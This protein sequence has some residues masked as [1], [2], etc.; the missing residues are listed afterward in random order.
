MDYRIIYVNAEAIFAVMLIILYALERSNRKNHMPRKLDALYACFIVTII[1]DSIWIIIDGQPRLRTF[2]MILNVV[3]LS[4][5]S[6]IGYLWFLYTLDMFPSRTKLQKIKYYLAIPVVLDVLIV[7]FSPITGWAFTIDESGYYQRGAL[8]ILSFLMNYVFTML[9]SYAALAARK[10]A[11][12][13]VDKKR[14]AVAAFFPVPIIVLTAIQF[15]LPPGLPAMQGGVMISLVLV[16]ATHQNV[17]VSRDPMTGLSNRFSFESDLMHR[18][19][20]YREK[21]TRLYL[22]EGDLDNLKS[23]NDSMGHPAGDRAIQLASEALSQVFSPFG[24]L[25]F[26]LG[27]DEFMVIVETQEALEA[28]ALR[29]QL[30]EVL[31]EKAGEGGFSMGLSMSLGATEYQGDTDF[32][33]LIK[34]A[35]ADLYEIKAK[36]KRLA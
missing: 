21:G 7:I 4:I 30:N 22:M 20:N 25:V 35:D 12:L 3:Y 36:R 5:T 31:S 6:F 16:Y 17:L 1:L 2:N 33:S 11:L 9:G 13:S 18:M 28:E 29:R 23:I 15:V 8:H 10:E 34:M 26:R 32:R 27:G 14:L 19:E 24:S